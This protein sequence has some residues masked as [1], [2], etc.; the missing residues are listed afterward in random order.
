MRRWPC[1]KQKTEETKKNPEESSLVI[2][3]RWMITTDRALVLLLIEKGIFTHDE[4]NTKQAEQA[5]LLKTPI[6]K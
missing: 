3:T 2:L 5:E 1:K 6:L 4:F